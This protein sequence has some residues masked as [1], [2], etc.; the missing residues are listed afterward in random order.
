MVT[1]ELVREL[2]GDYSSERFVRVLKKA[3]APATFVSVEKDKIDENVLNHI[4]DDL[5]ENLNINAWLGEDEGKEGTAQVE[6]SVRA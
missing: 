5:D 1:K 2:I 3:C 6:G 4:Q